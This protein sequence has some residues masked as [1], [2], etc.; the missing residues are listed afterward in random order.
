MTLT[1]LIVEV[2]KDAGLPKAKVARVLRSFVKTTKA[3]LLSG[4]R[5]NLRAFGAFYTVTPKPMALFG[6][7]R[8]SSGRTIIRF[9]EARH[10]KV[11]RPAR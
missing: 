8:R 11:Q 1:E 9:K 5:V 10:G 2:A 3:A 4:E 6:G 7:Q